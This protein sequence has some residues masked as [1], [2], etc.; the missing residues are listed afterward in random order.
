MM[1][2]DLEPGDYF[3]N[4]QEAKVGQ[5]TRYGEIEGIG[6]KIG[7]PKED[8]NVLLGREVI[9]SVSTKEYKDSTIKD[10]QISKI[11]KEDF[12]KGLRNLFEGFIKEIEETW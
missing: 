12:I 11:D 1:K 10:K 8:A 2:T 5:I 4:A 9:L 6:I 3:F 7:V